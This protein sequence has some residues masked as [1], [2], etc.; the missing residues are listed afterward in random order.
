MI[1]QVI[2]IGRIVS[3]LKIETNE[4]GM[5]IVNIKIAV[6]RNYKNSDG[7]YDT[8][9]IPCT[10]T[11]GIAKNTVEYCK[12]GDLISVHGNLETQEN[13]LKVIANRVTCLA[14]SN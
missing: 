9:F 14:R 2:L 10:I 4:N 13:R 7:M 1:N 6:P 12:K 3:D 8:D 11:S 5:E